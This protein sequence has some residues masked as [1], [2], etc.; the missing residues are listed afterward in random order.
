MSDDVYTIAG[1]IAEE[2]ANEHCGYYKD[3]S[4]TA[5]TAF[6]RNQLYRTWGLTAHRGW[7]RLLPD[8]RCLVQ[9]PNAPRHH[10]ERSHVRDDDDEQTAFDSYMNPE[11][12]FHNGPGFQGP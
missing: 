2:L 4:T 6:F 8:R 12:G 3:T 1:A 5:V 10:T 7:A 11:A 9:I